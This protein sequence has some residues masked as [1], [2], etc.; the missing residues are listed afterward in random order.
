MFGLTREAIINDDLSVFARIPQMF[1]AAAIRKKCGLVYGVL[2]DNAA[3]RNTKALSHADHSNLAG[4]A[5]ALSVTSLDSAFAEMR[6]QKAV[7]GEGYCLPLP[8]FLI[9]PPVLEGAARIL[10]N[11][12]SNDQA[13]TSGTI[14][15]GA[16][17]RYSD[18]KIVVEPVLQESSATAWYLAAN[19]LDTISLACLDG[20]NE[21]VSLDSEDGFNVDGTNYKVRLEC[22]AKAIDWRGL[23]KNASA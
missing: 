14:V 11:A 18:L 10:V 1:V 7:G 20:S 13:G 4:T 19:N 5:A 8:R 15:T 16:A 21:G 9:I 22:A 23:Y 3:M 2:N 6:M 12:M 17:N